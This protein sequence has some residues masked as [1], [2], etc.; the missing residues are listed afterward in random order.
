M[1][2]T[3]LI[4]Q[5]S[6]FTLAC[7][8]FQVCVRVYLKNVT[9]ISVRRYDYLGNVDLLIIAE[10]VMKYQLMKQSLFAEEN[11]MY[12]HMSYVLPFV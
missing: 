5:Q 1:S 4:L 10:G 7:E 11:K 8:N 12:C 2:F 3:L 6:F 9:D